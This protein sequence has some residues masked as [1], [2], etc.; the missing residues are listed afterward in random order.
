MSLVT[1]LITLSLYACK[2]NAYTLACLANTNIHED[3]CMPDIDTQRDAHACLPTYIYTYIHTC[4]HIYT[5][6]CICICTYTLNGRK[7][8]HTCAHPANILTYY[9][10][11]HSCISAYIQTYLH[12]YSYLFV[13]I[14]TY[15]HAYIDTFLH[16]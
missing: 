8:A 9:I 11:A 2:Y 16:T 15:M 4:I 14:D 13:C 5:H 7:Y 3:S 10:H 12:D 1:L 6:V